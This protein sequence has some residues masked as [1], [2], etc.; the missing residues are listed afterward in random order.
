MTAREIMA[1]LAVKHNEDL[2]ISECKDGPTVG[3]DHL[4][5]D[6]WALRRSWT[7]P[8]SFGYEIKVSRSD[9]MRDGKLEA[10]L[11]L[12]H[13]LSVV[14]PAGL[15]QPDEM[16]SGVGL[17]WVTAGASRLYTKRRAELRS[18]EWPVALML[19]VLFSRV[20][21]TSESAP[22]SAE[23]WRNWLERKAESRELGYRVGE[24]IRRRVEKAETECAAMSRKY[25]QVKDVE[26][27]LES[28][29]LGYI[30]NWK[31]GD[32][33]I[34]DVMRTVAGD[35]GNLSRSLEDA[36]RQIAYTRLEIDKALAVLG[37]EGA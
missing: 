9:W 10:Y 13:K 1:L 34:K 32:Q 23:Y 7:Q 25:E 19:Y 5:L 37:K 14:C 4:R 16:P 27:R 17:L 28:L 22:S 18:I 21:P 33:I 20:R 31:T 11:P 3:C 24:A 29:G 36:A 26:A 6:A 30:A 35:V 15:I 2:F 8:C 12:C